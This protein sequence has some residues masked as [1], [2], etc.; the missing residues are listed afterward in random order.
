MH[1][2]KKKIVEKVTL[3]VLMDDWRSKKKLGV[4]KKQP[5]SKE[6]VNHDKWGQL[7]KNGKGY[8]N[9]LETTLCCLSMDRI[10]VLTDNF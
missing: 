6:D 10:K 9:F 1:I 7:Q 5:Q 2:L 8:E 4:L 3:S